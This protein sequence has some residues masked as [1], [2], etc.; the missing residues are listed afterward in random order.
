MGVRVPAGAVP[1]GDITPT[2]LQLGRYATKLPYPSPIEGE[3]RWL[4]IAELAKSPNQKGR[5]AFTGR[6]FEFG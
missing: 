1:A 5:P 3:G 2:Q 4:P 6:P